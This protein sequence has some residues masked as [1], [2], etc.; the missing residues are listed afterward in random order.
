[1]KEI[2]EENND[3][4]QDGPDSWI[5][6]I[7]SPKD[8]SLVIWEDGWVLKSPIEAVSQLHSLQ[9]NS[10]FLLERESKRHTSTGR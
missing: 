8:W 9:V 6:A 2:A 5:R 10:R 1:M 3:C 7:S 4:L